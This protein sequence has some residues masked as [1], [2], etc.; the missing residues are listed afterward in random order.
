MANLFD[1]TA[2][3]IKGSPFVIWVCTLLVAMF[4]IG[5][6]CFMEDTISS[7]NGIEALEQ[8]F[9][10]KPTNLPIAYFAVS[11]I[12][13]VGQAVLSYMYLMD[14]KKNWWA[15]P[16]T[17]FF[18]SIDFV[19]DVQDRSNQQFIPLTRTI[20]ADGTLSPVVSFG[21]ATIVASAFTLTAYTLG[22]EL[23]L[24]VS[25]GM[26]LSLVK[27]GIKQAAILYVGIANELA[28]ARSQIAQTR[29]RNPRPSQ[30]GHP[31]GGPQKAEPQQPRPQQQFGGGKPQQ[32]NGGGG[33]Q[34]QGGGQQ[35]QGGGHQP[36]YGLTN[37]PVRQQQGQRH[38]GGGNVNGHQSQRPIHPATEAELDALFEGMGYRNE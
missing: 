2:N 23:F 1:D 29:Q 9:G 14:R 21:G 5:I 3:K 15:L 24:S 19:F 31:Q 7:R 13:Q 27:D 18:F 10:I 17:I 22:S 6:I 8:V 35:K 16:L 28:S 37:P 20:M 4:F 11:L 26:F 32:H 36:N 34:K 33:Q 25:I 38:Q 30:T 12:P